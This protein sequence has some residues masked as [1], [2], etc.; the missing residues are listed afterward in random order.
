MN[1]FEYMDIH[2][3][4]DQFEYERDLWYKSGSWVQTSRTAIYEDH[5]LFG[6]VLAKLEL[7]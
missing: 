2:Q 6:I 1:F 7:I 3:Y 5:G 4:G